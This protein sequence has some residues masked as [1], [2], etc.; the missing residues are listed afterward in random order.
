MST[1]F[2]IAVYCLNIHRCYVSQDVPGVGIDAIPH[3]Y[4]TEQA[5][6]AE[7]P[8]GK[9]DDPSK[10]PPVYREVHRNSSCHAVTDVSCFKGGSVCT[11]A[12]ADDLAAE[13]LKSMV[14][15]P[16]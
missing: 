5:C 9:P 2:W 7:I 13:K 16:K 1:I 3:R 12:P 15:I 4:P 10:P 14:V 6:K 8:G 11:F